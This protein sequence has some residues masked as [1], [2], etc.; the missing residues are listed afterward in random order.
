VGC[1]TNEGEQKNVCGTD[2]I[3]T[4]VTTTAGLGD[5]RGKKIQKEN[6]LNE[7]RLMEVPEGETA[8]TRRSEETNRCSRDDEGNR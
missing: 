7:S 6:T 3:K 4:Q 2:R 5:K 8:A 1:D